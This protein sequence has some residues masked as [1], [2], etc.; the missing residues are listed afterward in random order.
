VIAHLPFQAV[1]GGPA[2]YNAS[3]AEIP[4]AVTDTTLAERLRR[5]RV[6]VLREGRVLRGD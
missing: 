2:P 3:V 6:T 1:R 5:M 4:N